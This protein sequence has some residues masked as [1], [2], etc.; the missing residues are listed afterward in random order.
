MCL[1]LVLIVPPAILG[2]DDLRR[3]QEAGWYVLCRGK[4]PPFSLCLNLFLA[5]RYFARPGRIFLTRCLFM[6][7]PFL[8]LD[9]LHHLQ[10]ATTSSPTSGS[11][12]LRFHSFLPLFVP[13]TCPVCHLVNMVPGHRR[14]SARTVG[15][16]ECP[17]SFL[18]RGHGGSRIPPPPS[19]LCP[20]GPQDYAS[21]V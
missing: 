8:V 2:T 11:P 10:T 9:M 20:L 7:L 18:S 6:F 13:P 1:A 14:G 21:A 3:P 16:V 12:L 5:C 17:G 15:L 4:F 19:L